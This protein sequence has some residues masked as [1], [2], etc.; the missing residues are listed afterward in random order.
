MTILG[1]RKRNVH[2]LRG[3]SIYDKQQYVPWKSISSFGN[4]KVLVK[5]TDSDATFTVDKVKY[6]TSSG[7]EITPFTYQ[8]QEDTRMLMLNGKADTETEGIE[9][10]IT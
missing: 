8:G 2:Q 5:I 7:I 9:A 4:D 10:Y 1:Q 3:V 6:R